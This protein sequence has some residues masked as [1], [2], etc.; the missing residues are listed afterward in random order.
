MEMADGP[1][2]IDEDMMDGWVVHDSLTLLALLCLLNGTGIKF[3][4]DLTRV[5]CA[6]RLIELLGKGVLHAIGADN[7]FNGFRCRAVFRKLQ[8]VCDHEKNFSL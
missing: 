7:A 1:I 6:E 3:S 4:R 5:N 2:D 8:S